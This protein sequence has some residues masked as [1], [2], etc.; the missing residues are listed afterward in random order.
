[1]TDKR[2]EI[3]DAEGCL[4]VISRRR[5]WEVLVMP[6]RLQEEWGGEIVCLGAP[7]EVALRAKLKPPRSE[8][9]AGEAGWAGWQA[10]REG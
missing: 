1:M 6:A 9:D 10:G 3:P 8:K 2:G 4:F 7:Q 5:A